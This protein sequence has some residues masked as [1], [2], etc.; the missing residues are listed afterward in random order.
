MEKSS[1]RK[2]EKQRPQSPSRLQK[3]NKSDGRKA[4]ESEWSNTRSIVAQ[5]KEGQKQRSRDAS[6][7]KKAQEKASGQKLAF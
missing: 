2:N 3:W 4:K 5:Q 6:A 7:S 1:Q